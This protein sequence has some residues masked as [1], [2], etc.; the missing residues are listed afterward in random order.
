MHLHKCSECHKPF[1]QAGDLR[2][3]TVTYS[4]EYILAHSGV[5]N[6][7]CSEC[8][9]SFGQSGNLRSHMI[10]HTGDRECGDSFGLAEHLK[11]HNVI[12]RVHKQTL[13][14]ITSKHIPPKE[15]PNQCKCSLLPSQM[16]FLLYAAQHLLTHSGE[17]SHQ[18]KD[19]GSSFSRAGHLKRHYLTHSSEKPHKCTQCDYACLRA[20]L[21]YHALIKT[22]H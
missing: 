10:T 18:C 12:R 22:L 14:Q 13:L 6:P 15:K 21:S 20:C 5:K 2:R 7:T 1:H 8:D 11:R 19:C 3:R 9:K 4:K 17:R 16:I